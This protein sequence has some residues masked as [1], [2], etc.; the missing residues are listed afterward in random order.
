MATRRTH[1]ALNA[2]HALS[3]DIYPHL[4]DFFFSSDEFIHW[5]DGR[6]E[7]RRLHCSGG[8][9]SGKS[10][11]SVLAA[12]RLHDRFPEVPV[13]TLFI[14]TD[15]RHSEAAFVEDF[16]AT[17]CRQLDSTGEDDELDACIERGH[18]KRAAVRIHLIREVLYKRLSSHQRAF[19]VLDGVDGCSAALEMLLDTELASLQQR[20]LSVLVTSRL[21]LYEKPE[22]VTCDVHA[23]ER[24]TLFW[25]C[26]VCHEFIICYPCK[27][28]TNMCE[29]W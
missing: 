4:F 18:G 28:K 5:R 24:L 7:W 23:S 13:A 27:A 10:I 2:S 25:E 19:L 11:L 15:I 3:S 1:P 9:G 16:L 6:H 8:P 14:S 21:P 22:E 26:G 17:A 12:G 20:G 29:I